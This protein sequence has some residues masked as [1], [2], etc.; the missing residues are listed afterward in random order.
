VGICIYDRYDW[1]SGKVMYKAKCNGNKGSII[2][3][4]GMLCCYDENTGDALMAYDI[5]SK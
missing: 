3:A 4:D 1:D 2:H 5:K